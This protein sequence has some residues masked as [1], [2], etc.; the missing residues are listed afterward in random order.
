M[1]KD[2]IVLMQ[3]SWNRVLPIKNEVGIIFYRKLFEAAPQVRYL[4]KDDVSAQ[5]GKLVTMLGYIVTKLNRM[6]ELLPEVKKLGERH[7]QFGAEP[8]H[9]ELVGQCLIA[10]LEE[11]L[12]E[13]WTPEIRDAWITAYNTLKNVMIVAQS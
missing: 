10:T 11:G 5:A 2:Q 12:G 9:Y 4:F 7:Q 3:Q 1:T 8:A 6:D 13:N